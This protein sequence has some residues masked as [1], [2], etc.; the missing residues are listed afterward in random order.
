MP[1]K[2]LKF[3]AHGLRQ[4]NKRFCGFR[5]RALPAIRRRLLRLIEAGRV[6]AVVGEDGTGQV[7]RVQHGR[8]VLVCQRIRRDSTA[9]TLLTCF[10]CRKS[11][12][13]LNEVHQ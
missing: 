13:D 7:V 2:Q 5:R 11:R 4:L 6:V 9:F 12:E 1:I 3:T 10:R 8:T